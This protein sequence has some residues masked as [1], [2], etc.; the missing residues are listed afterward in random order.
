MDTNLISLITIAVTLILGVA[1]FCVN[2]YLQRRNNSIHIITQKRVDRRTKALE[3][4]A[5]ILR[6]SDLN[7]LKVMQTEECR[8]ALV[9]ELTAAVAELRANYSCSFVQD[10]LLCDNV[11]V[12]EAAV[13]EY[14]ES[15]A[16]AQSGD[17][18]ERLRAARAE[19]IKVA[20][21]YSQTDWSRIKKETVGKT[22]GRKRGKINFRQSL[23]II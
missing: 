10:K 9:S 22:A 13:C 6:C 8:R 14:L 19:V 4:V 11:E 16:G 3:N 18:E 12:L 1:G 7:Y 20:D 17:I 23:M 21:V 15:G 2:T 5:V